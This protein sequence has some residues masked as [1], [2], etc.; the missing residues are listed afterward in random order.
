[1]EPNKTC[2]FTG[3]RRIP[4]DD[5]PFVAAALRREI[6]RLVS[7]EGIVTFLS[8]G[9]VG[10]DTLAAETVLDVAREAPGVSLV[11]V[12]PCA[13]Q[14]HGWSARD[15][16][17]HDAILA[18]ANEVVTLA[19]A[20]RPGCMQ[21]RN[22][23]LVDHSSVVLCYLT[24]RSGGTAYTVRYAVSQGLPIINTAPAQTD[25]LSGL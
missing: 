14:A 21:A 8:G 1:M 12:R 7:E 18:R 6:L 22:R 11:I 17:R 13:D 15:A 19:P 10:F 9:A 4:P 2:C 20:Y 3:H 24:E 5:L 25:L 23:Y 16:A